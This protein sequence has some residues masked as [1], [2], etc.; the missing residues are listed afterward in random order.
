LLQDDTTKF[1]S[2]LTPLPGLV[3]VPEEGQS[4]V[5]ER[6]EIGEEDGETL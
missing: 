4:K 5:K 2:D 3:D 1:V 6:R